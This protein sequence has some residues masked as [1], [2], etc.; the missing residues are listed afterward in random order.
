MLS[1]RLENLFVAK[2]KL[3]GEGKQREWEGWRGEGGGR[4]SGFGWG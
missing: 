3:R 4:D 1:K 2:R